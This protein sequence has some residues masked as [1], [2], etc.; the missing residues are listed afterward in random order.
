VLEIIDRLLGREPAQKAVVTGTG[1]TGPGVLA[2]YNDVPLWQAQKN[3]RRL[4]RQ[5]QELYHRDLVIRAAERR[6]SGATSGLPW[7]LEDEDGEEVGDD[8][9]PDILAIRDWLEKPQGQ[10]TGRNQMTRRQLWFLT[11]RH[12]GLCGNA[13]WYLDQRTLG[14]G[15]PL[16]TLYINPAR[17]TP[18]QN[19]DGV[20]LGWKMDADDDGT[21]GVPL[22][23]EEVRQFVLEPPDWGHY[24]IGL[25]ES[26]G[27][28]AALSGSITKHATN[29]VSAG[30]RLAGLIAPKVG[31]TVNDDAWDRAVKD[32]RN[33]SA[34]PESAKRLHI[35]RGPV[36]YTRTAAT[37]QELAVDALSKMAREDK[38]ALW[39]VPGSQVPYPQSAG[40][41]S[42]ETKGYDEAVLMQG[43][44]HDRVTILRELIQFQ[45]L[46]RI[47]EQGGPQVEL[48]IHE[49][50]F[51][52]ETPMFDRAQK[53]RDL[54]LT[55]N[56]RRAQVGLEPLP[57]L[58]ANGEPLGSAI[59]LPVGLTMVGAGPDENG[60]LVAL[61]EPDPQP[62]PVPTEEEE[63]AEEE[64][65]DALKASLR[66][67]VEVRFVAS[68]KR[69]VQRALADQAKAIAARIRSQGDHIA[70]RPKDTSVW[71]TPTEEKR[72]ARVL[73][74]Q[75]ARIGTLV[76]E[77]VSERMSKPA[78]ADDFVDSVLEF[79][80][81]RTGERILDINRTTRETIAGLIAEGFASGLG[82]AEVADRIEAST[83]FNEA[84]AELIARTETMLA[85]NDANLSS[86]REFGVSEVEAID[87]D[88][89]D[90][91]ASR[92]GQVYPIE[93]AFGIFDHP[94]GTLD[95]APV[96]KATT[97]PVLELTKAVL[98][99]A[100]RP[101]PTPIVN[102]YVTTPDMPP[103][104]VYP[105]EV[106]VNVPEPR[107]TR[108]V[109]ERNE[110]GSIKAVT[111]EP[112]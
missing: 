91:C 97:D 34:D 46:D 81:K 2:W 1:G 70:R 15:M 83:A 111:E 75:N 32:W 57:D 14:T 39:G 72:L 68:T 42:G 106:V 74:T 51:D 26:A 13:F 112:A 98:E 84:R 29:V 67:R 90:E 109:V 41:N 44:V 10:L 50:E 37:M 64:T 55:A 7:H 5:A 107:P 22:T 69:D 9:P 71:W 48:V 20:L 33:I 78:K 17:M 80:R 21:G 36:D 108:K 62:V 104:T 52:D 92:N 73:E 38:L 96:I 47:A 16:V 85:Y 40:L 94:N 63:E 43:A 95:W 6:V 93:E 102:N 23:L 27:E 11:S 60:N 25:V 100:E 88:E 65:P 58:D 28:A 89:D 101:Q 19:Q 99:L 30:A 54:P 103:V 86:F 66:D 18:V 53:A 24:G 59:W 12:V 49:P 8:A 31:V 77:R 110:D 4:M 82:P 61:P 56:E 35:L 105:T 76:T 79:I 87:G 3:P 45:I